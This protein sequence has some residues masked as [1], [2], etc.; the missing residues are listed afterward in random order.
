MA[1]RRTRHK[2]HRHPVK[3]LSDAQEFELMKLVLDKF[4]WLGMALIGVGIYFMIARLDLYDGVPYILSGL[5]VMLVF[6][7]TIVRYFESYSS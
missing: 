1:K 3:H 5:G 7:L 4:L 2:G 6:G